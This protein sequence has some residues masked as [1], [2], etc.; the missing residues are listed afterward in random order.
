MSEAAPAAVAAVIIPNWNGAHLLPGCLD[1]LRLQTRQDFTV[2]VVDNGSTDPSRALLAE[3]YPEVR[4]VALVENVGFA[5]GVNAGIRATCEPW[6]ILLNNDTEAAPDWI[7]HLVGEMERREVFSFGASK[8]LDYRRRD[9]IDSVADGFGRFGLPFKIGVDEIDA[10]QYDE[11]FETFAAC[12]AASIYR[13]SLLDEIGLFDERFFAYIEDVDISMRA[14]V[15]GHRCLAVTTARV[16]HIGTASSGGGPSALTLRLTA[17]NVPWAMVKSVP[18]GLLWWMLPLSF[19][20]QWAVI[21]HSLLLG[22][23]P[24]LRRN[25][26]AYAIGVAQ[27]LRGL[28]H[29]LRER[30]LGVRRLDSAAFAARLRLAEAQRSVSRATR[31]GEK[32]KPSGIGMFLRR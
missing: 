7:A 20:A 1:S 19:L 32:P 26:R 31:Y 24:W 15:A 18:A 4:V 27:G 30:R 2:C 22:S 25:L 13:R 28:P 29:A 11:P 8:L 3:R 12:A 21:A 6:V 9:V 17:R 5:A 23:R 14:Q 16:F 10:G